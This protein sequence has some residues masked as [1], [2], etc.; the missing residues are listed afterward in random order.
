MSKILISGYYGFHNAGDDAVLH[1]IITSLH[2]K[3][4]SLHLGVLS[5]Q[6]EK[7]E[8]LFRVRAYDRW[9]LSEV[10]KTIKKYD[11]LLM[12]GGS[13][14]QDTTSPRSVLYYL[15]I[16][17]VAK[18]FR[19]PVVFYAQG[20]GPINRR[21]SKRLIKAVVNKVDVITVRDFESGEDLKRFGVKAPIIVTA[22]P[23]VT[24]ER[25]QVDL[26]FGANVLKER[27]IDGEK[28]LAISVRSWKREQN[29]LQQ[30]AVVADHYA[31]AGWDI[32]FLP[33]QYSEDVVACE[34]IMTRMKNRAH[35]IEQ[36][37]N[38]KEIISVIGNVRFM[39]GMRL[40]SIILAAVMNVPFVAISY[41]PKIE[42]FVE[43]LNMYSAGHITN[44]NIEKLLEYIDDTLQREDEVKESI[45]KSMKHIIREAERSSELTLAQLKR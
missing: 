21:L 31:E 3:E 42:R 10:V 22:D 32:L 38:F 27:N 19:K 12:G 33:M 5:N 14:L 35:L 18:L 13:L 6:P 26:T 45:A 20:V 43:R 39:L 28:T 44:L 11:L 41:D 9:N 34:Q 4:P 29:Y 24:I 15:G 36:Q 17:T 8:K 2:K 30:L 7:T 16:V 23:A 40:H 37:L 25:E 1:G